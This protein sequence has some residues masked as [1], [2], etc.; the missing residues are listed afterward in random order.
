MNKQNYKK[1]NA[2]NTLISE[3]EEMAQSGSVNYMEKNIFNRII[4]HYYKEDDLEMALGVID[5]AI[6]QHTYSSEFY[7]RKAQIL[8]AKNKNNEALT[9]LNKASIYAPTDMEIA[10]LKAEAY[11]SIDEF[12][13]ALETLN[14]VK[15]GLS[16]EDLSQV[17]IAEAMVYERSENYVSMFLSL[18]NAILTHIGNTEALERIWFCVELSEMFRE[19]ID[20]H[21]KIIDLDPYS[22]LA[23]YN[24][25]H[26]YSCIESFEEAIQ[27]YEYAFI[28]NDK[29]EFAYRDCAEVCLQIA[30]YKQALGFYQEALE[31]FEPDCDLYTKVGFCYEHLNNFEKAKSFYCSAVKIDPYNDAVH[32]RL[33]ICFSKEDKWH[34]AIGAFKKAIELN[35]RAE[36]Y[37]AALAEAYYALGDTKSA[38]IY[39]KNA[40]DIA[41]EEGQYWIKYA[42]F[43]VDIDETYA[44]LNI[45]DDA[46][47]FAGGIELIYSRVACLFSLGERG[48]ALQL[49]GQAL[50]ENFQLHQSLFRMMPALTLDSDVLFMIETYNRY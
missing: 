28:I 44:A 1:R 30:D 5:H 15:P 38:N 32:Y 8:L 19:S 27:A 29:F 33:G 22:Y 50:E 10:L 47:E 48:E 26:A 11:S 46:D 4:E 25:G 24:L 6:T 43:L 21:L 7:I 20:L 45:L 37:H 2:L 18:K 16:K 3:Y 41:P 23:W 49:L 34:S 13:I 39:F 40:V 31:K 9:Y 14:D 42:G 12:E 17:N 36:E 35:K